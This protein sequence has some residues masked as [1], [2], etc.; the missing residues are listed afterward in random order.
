MKWNP[1]HL[2][3]S[4][5]SETLFELANC[6]IVLAGEYAVLDGAPAIVLVINRGVECEIARVQGLSP[7]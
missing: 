7:Q 3:T 4:G 5:T 6:K 2:R 1:P